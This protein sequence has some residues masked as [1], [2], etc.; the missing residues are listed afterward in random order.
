M[1]HDTDSRWWEI[2]VFL[3]KGKKKKIEN[4]SAHTATSWYLRRPFCQLLIIIQIHK[5][6]YSS[7]V[8]ILLLL[9]LLFFKR[10]WYVTEDLGVVGNPWQGC[11]CFQFAVNP[12]GVQHTITAWG[13]QLLHVCYSMLAEAGV[14]IQNTAFPLCSGMLS[15]HSL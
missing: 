3:Q 4:T 9:L 12:S 5:N 13:V 1:L 14:H 7:C 15:R 10:L 6:G 8:Q 2:N 11:S